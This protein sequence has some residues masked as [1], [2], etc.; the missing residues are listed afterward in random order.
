[1]SL[2]KKIIFS[3][4]LMVLCL[5]LIEFSAFVAL[6]ILNQKPKEESQNVFHPLRHHAYRP[7]IQLRDTHGGL[8]TDEHGYIKNDI[9]IKNPAITIL[10]TGASTLGTQTPFTG[11]DKTMSS[12]IQALLNERFDQPIHVQS[13]SVTSYPSFNELMIL[14]EYLEDYNLDADIVVSVNGLFASYDFIDNL[15][16]YLARNNLYDLYDEPPVERLIQYTDGEITMFPRVVFRVLLSANI[17]TVRLIQYVLNKTSKGVLGNED[18]DVNEEKWLKYKSA[19][20]V[21]A[22]QEKL[23]R[24][25]R[26]N[27]QMMNDVAQAHG[28]QFFSVLLPAAYTW[29]NWPQEN[30]NGQNKLKAFYQAR[31]YN[32]LT[33]TQATYPVY[34]FT[35]I[36][37]DLDLAQNP[38][39]K[40]DTVHYNDIGTERVAHEIYK[41]L[42]PYV[43]TVLEKKEGM[44]P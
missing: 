10:L 30:M 43:K 6:T 36:F 14:Y 8:F 20:P 35:P 24:R 1:M 38:Y 4:I 16:D 26:L 22:L 42:I 41:K 40:D 28:M 27:Y 37:D 12:R 44:T 39:T 9:E 19:E 25:E 23:I 3:V 29:K 7:N 32:A 15:E 2:K 31:F 5:G 17:N 13:L 33:D 21:K 11:A 34:D 18:S